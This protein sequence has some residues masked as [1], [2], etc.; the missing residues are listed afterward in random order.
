MAAPRLGKDG[1]VLIGAA[2]AAHITDWELAVNQDALEKTAFGDGW[3]RT[4]TV[5]LRGPVATINGYY[6]DTDTAQSALTALIH[7]TSTPASVTVVLLTNSTTGAKAGWTGTAIPQLTVGSA[8][9]AID[10]ISGTFQFTGGVS[11]YAT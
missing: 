8:Q 10:T 3:D 9:D 4:Y 11:T 2:T 7:S 1:S 5:G 6:G